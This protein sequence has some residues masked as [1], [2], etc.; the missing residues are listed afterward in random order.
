MK[1][2]ILKLQN[3]QR[4]IVPEGDYGRA[5]IWLINDF[6]F[7]FEIPMYGGKPVYY[8]H[9]YQSKIAEMIKEIDGL[10]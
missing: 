8:N 7:V 2:E 3:G 4:Y 5:E 1:D 9:Y 6:Y 10:T